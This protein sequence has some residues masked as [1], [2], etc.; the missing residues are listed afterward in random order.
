MRHNTVKISNF[1]ISNNLPFFLIAGPCSIENK[2]HAIHHAGVINEICSKLKINFVYKSSFDKANR[3]SIKSK[4]GVGIEKGLSILS[5]VKSILN[6]PILTDVHETYQCKD[7]GEI[8]D[9]V[10]IPA[11]LCRQT[12]LLYAAAKTKKNYKC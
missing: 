6:I 7:V 2:D 1:E 12:D 11:F 5:D 9:I 10:Q 4:R 3:S 8:V